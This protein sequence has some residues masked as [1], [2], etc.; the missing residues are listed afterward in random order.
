MQLDHDCLYLQR[1]DISSINKCI[2]ID[3]TDLILTK[4]TNREKVHKQYLYMMESVLLWWSPFV[5]NVDC[6]KTDN[7]VAW[8]RLKACDHTDQSKQQ[9]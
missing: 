8:A 4:I 5:A 3:Y 1:N 7:T 2:G 6:I 9:K